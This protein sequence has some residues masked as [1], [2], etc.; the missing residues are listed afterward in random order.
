MK[1]AEKE[2][3]ENLRSH[4]MVPS[5]Y[6]RGAGPGLHPVNAEAGQLAHG[7]LSGWNRMEYTM[8]GQDYFVL[9]QQFTDLFS[10]QPAI[11]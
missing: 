4:V 2:V 10:R 11:L 9:L 3:V 8:I 5:L 1:K 7:L 6:L